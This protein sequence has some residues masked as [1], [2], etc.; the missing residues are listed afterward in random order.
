[1]NTVAASP[2]SSHTTGTG[3]EIMRLMAAPVLGGLLVVDEVIDL[4]LLVLFY[5]GRARLWRKLHAG[6]KH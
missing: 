1:L 4:L 6:D 2:P 3:A 5:H